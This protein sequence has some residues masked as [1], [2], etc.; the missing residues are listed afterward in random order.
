MVVSTNDFT[1][2][3]FASEVFF[4]EGFALCAEVE[5]FDAT[6][7]FM[8]EFHHPVRVEIVAIGA[9]MLLFPVLHERD[10]L[11]L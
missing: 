10:G 5:S 2:C 7:R 1:L 9:W 6:D 3:H 4:G 8:V 11:A